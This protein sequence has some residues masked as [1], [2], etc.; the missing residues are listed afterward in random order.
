MN[1]LRERISLATESNLK[2]RHDN[3]PAYVLHSY[4]YR[5]TSLVAELFTRHHGRIALVARGAKRAK[6]AVRGVLQ[7]F[8]P[9]SVSWF[10]KS[11]LRT[12]VKAEWQRALPQL[13]GTALMSGF[14]LNE[15]LLKLTR[16]DDTHE[17]LFDYYG[18]AIAAL[19]GLET[20]IGSISV[21]LRRF[22]LGLLKE[23]GYAVPLEVD[24]ETGALV[25]DGG[26]FEYVIESGPIAVKPSPD[27]VQ[28]RGKTLLDIV[29]DDY[30]DSVTIQETKQLM[31]MLINHY[32]GG[33]LLHT[34]QFI[35]DLRDF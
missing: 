25:A 2:G 27:R 5:E 14:Y 28:F 35:K 15:L 34:R 32:L 10:G 20:G 13:S 4:P 12:L 8:Q 22:E 19:S 17:R 26:T 33:Q 16:R 18:R 11:E 21:L 29:R 7:P 30:S 1:S 3:E 9:L 31:R 23:F 6:S 24:V